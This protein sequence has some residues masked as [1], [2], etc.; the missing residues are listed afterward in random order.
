MVY[1][2]VLQFDPTAQVL[3]FG[4]PLLEGLQLPPELL[5]LKGRQVFLSSSVLSAP[6][7]DDDDHKQ[8]KTKKIN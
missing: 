4:V 7:D 3:V 6:G 2:P 1:L 5:T 8:R